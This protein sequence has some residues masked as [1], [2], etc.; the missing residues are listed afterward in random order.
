VEVYKHIRYR[1]FKKNTMRNYNKELDVLFEEWENE[2]EKNG[3]TG[4]CR[5]GLLLKGKKFSKKSEE[6]GKTYWGRDS[7]N[8]NEQWHNAKKRILFLMKDTNRNPGEDMRTWIG[9]QNQKF[10]TGM[11]FKNIALWLTGLNS[12]NDKYNYLPFEEAI[13]PEVFTDTFDNLPISIVN[14]KK[15]SGKGT[16]NNG[17]LWDYV[18]KSKKYGEFLKR[19]IKILNPNIVVCGGVIVLKIARKI[20]YP[21][22]EFTEINNWIYFNS[23]KNIVLIES[24]H[25]SRS[26][27]KD[28]YE[29]MMEAFKEHLIKINE[30]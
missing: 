26:P 24:N 11:F 28:N 30:R 19:Q 12:F 1:S 20:I 10:I 27:Y 7:G 18:D 15:E 21:D 2:S 6:D 14:I 9:R 25:P 8:E 5:D 23:E 4:F 29:G 22:V 17:V 13:I 3:L 16:V